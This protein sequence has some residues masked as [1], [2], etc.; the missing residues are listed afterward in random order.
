MCNRVWNSYWISVI[1]G[2]RKNTKSSLSIIAIKSTCG[3]GF[4]VITIVSNTFITF[5]C[6]VRGTWIQANC[7]VVFNE[8]GVT[9]DIGR[10]RETSTAS[11]I[12]ETSDTD[13]G[14]TFPALYIYIY[15]PSHI[16]LEKGIH[17]LGTC[18]NQHYRLHKPLPGLQI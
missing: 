10:H 7:A 2:V 16:H 13:R 9:R 12:W 18:N 11:A 17:L 1:L 8:A 5:M 14:E 4:W 6:A 3:Q 15:I